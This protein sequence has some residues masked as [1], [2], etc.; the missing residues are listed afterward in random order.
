EDT[1]ENSC[2]CPK[3]H[4][5]PYVGALLSQDTVFPKMRRG[6]SSGWQQLTTRYICQKR[7]TTKFVFVRNTSSQRTSSAT[8]VAN[9]WELNQRICLSSLR[10]LR[11]SHGRAAGSD[12]HDLVNPKA[13]HRNE[14]MRRMMCVLLVPLVQDQTLVYS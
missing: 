3:C 13:F 1:A 4:R 9:Y 7:I 2:V 8:I 10:Y 11:S 5:A 6:A 12:H 14:C